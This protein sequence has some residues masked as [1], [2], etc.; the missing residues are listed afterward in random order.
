MCEQNGTCKYQLC[1]EVDVLI[2]RIE[3]SIAT[4]SRI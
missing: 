4:K 3:N 1:S 2:Y